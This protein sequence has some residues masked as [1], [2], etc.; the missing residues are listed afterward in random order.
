MNFPSVLIVIPI[1]NGEKYSGVT[2]HK[3]DN[4]IDTGEIIYQLKFKINFGDWKIKANYK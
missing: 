1:F 4:G 3:I 2:I